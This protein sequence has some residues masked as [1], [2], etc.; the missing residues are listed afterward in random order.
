VAIG[1]HGHDGT[2]NIDIK[3]DSTGQ[4]ICDSRAGFG[5][6]PLYIDP[7]HGAPHLSSMSTCIRAPVASVSNGQRVTMNAHYN[8]AKADD[9]QMGIVMA[10]V[11]PPRSS[12][13]G[14]CVTG[15]N[16]AHVA[17]GRATAF[18]F[19]VSA[20]GSNAYIGT[21]WETSSLREGPTGTWTKVA[22]C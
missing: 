9:M 6:S 3:N 4:M 22:S 14:G 10:F 5:E 21:T 2:I 13:P 19:W 12:G 1:G 17:A 20:K 8:M 16:E 18:I 11:G 15:T 7:E